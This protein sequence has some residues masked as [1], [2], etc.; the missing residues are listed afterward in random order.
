MSFFAPARDIYVHGPAVHLPARVMRNQDVIDWMGVHIRPSW[1]THRTGIEAR[2]WVDDDQACSDIATAAAA[3]LLSQRDIATS[4]IGQL[5][6]ATVSGD[7]PSPPT[8]PLVLRNLGIERAG[9]LDLGA[10]CA[11]FASGLHLCAGLHLATGEEH[12]LV[13]ADIRSKF[14]RRRDLATVA[15]F[16]DGAASCLISDRR[17]GADFRLLASELTANG[18][19]GDLIA[20]RAGGSRLP[21]GRNQDEDNLYLHMRSGAALFLEGVDL[22]VASARSLLARTGGSI[23]DV[24]WVVPHQANLHLIRAVTDKL[25]VPRDKV[26]ETVSFTGN[27]SGASVG[28]ALGHLLQRLPPER[29]SVCLTERNR[30]VA[31][32]PRRA[33]GV[34]GA[35]ATEKQRRDA[36]QIR[37][38]ATEGKPIGALRAGQRVL[39]VSAGAGG[40]A[41]SA[42][43][44]AL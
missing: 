18:S 31:S 20:I 25:G 39:L 13:A 28:I 4:R 37:G 23:D 43:L 44:A 11:G 10:A 3:E 5:V 42:L 8:A 33:E 1:I 38:F 16:G 17:D 9:A 15:L 35:W 19:V 2:H 29:Q 27:T 41:A 22:M 36:P 30:A 32:R 12:L 6:L 24:D 34:G 14:L 7:Y 26:V 40:A 21:A